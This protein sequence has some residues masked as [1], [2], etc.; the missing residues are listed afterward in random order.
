MNRPWISYLQKRAA[1]R[2][3]AIFRKWSAGKITAGMA[4]KMMKINNNMPAYLNVEPSEWIEWARSL[5]YRRE[6][7]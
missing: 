3:V 6:A 4:I 5:G 7:N 2:D 1:S